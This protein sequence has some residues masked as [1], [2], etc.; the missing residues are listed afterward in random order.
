MEFIIAGK[1]LQV[2]RSALNPSRPPFVK[3]RNYETSGLVV[4][5][6]LLLLESKPVHRR[7]QPCRGQSP[8][9]NSRRFGE[10]RYVHG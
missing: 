3:G 5:G 9:Y 7:I 2:G 6:P 8:C 10:N 4:E 1:Q